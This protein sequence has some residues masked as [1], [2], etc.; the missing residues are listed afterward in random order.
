M[1]LYLC[2]ALSTRKLCV[3]ILLPPQP[4]FELLVP[5]RLEVDLSIEET[6]SANC[7]E[8]L[9]VSVAKTDQMQKEKTR[10]TTKSDICVTGM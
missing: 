7:E 3:N 6:S 9:K 10:S 4:W 1:E 2:S 8:D 5:K